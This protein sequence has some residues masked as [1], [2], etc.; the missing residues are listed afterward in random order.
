MLSKLVRLKDKTKV[1]RGK[2]AVALRRAQARELEGGY[3]R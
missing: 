2:H 1:L 3:R